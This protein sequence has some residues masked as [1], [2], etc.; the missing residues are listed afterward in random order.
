MQVVV[1]VK[2]GLVVAQRAKA[3]FRHLGYIVNRE[4]I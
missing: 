4:S 2:T 3:H 1:N